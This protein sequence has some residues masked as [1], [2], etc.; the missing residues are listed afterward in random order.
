MILI[1]SLLLHLMVFKETQ[2]GYLDKDTEG[3]TLRGFFKSIS[4][5]MLSSLR[6]SPTRLLLRT[7][8]T[9]KG[10]LASRG[11]KVRSMKTFC[12]LAPLTATWN[13]TPKNTVI[14]QERVCEWRRLSAVPLDQGR[15][16]GRA[17]MLHLHLV[18]YFP[19]NSSNRFSQS[20]LQNTH[21]FLIWTQRD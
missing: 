1:R 6:A 2:E 17:D 15:V 16:P 10:L 20:S 4:E 14:T 7:W 3:L 12:R 13:S 21:V 9:R 11:S 18:L 8:R 19:P 5:W